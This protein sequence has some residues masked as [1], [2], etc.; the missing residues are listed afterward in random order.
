MHAALRIAYLVQHDEVCMFVLRF[1][2]RF[3]LIPFRFQGKPNDALVEL[4]RIL[5]FR[6]A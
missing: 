2:Q 4:G 1:T 3:G 5:L 6:F